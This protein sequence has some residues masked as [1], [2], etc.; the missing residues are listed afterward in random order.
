MWKEGG[1]SLR[2]AAL[3]KTTTNVCWEQ[4]DSD[5]DDFANRALKPLDGEAANQS[6]DATP[7]PI[8]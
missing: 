6:K 5:W 1:K 8:I 3:C 4:D 7:V 2:T